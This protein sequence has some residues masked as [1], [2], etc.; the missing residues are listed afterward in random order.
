MTDMAQEAPARPVFSRERLIRFSDCDAAGIVYYPQYFV[1]C[2][3][4]VEDWFNE[5]LGVEYAG[6]V[7][8]RRT[9]LP[10][11][12]LETDFT[13]PSH[14][15][16]RVVLSLGVERLGSRS[17]TLRIQCTGAT[18]GV[19]RMS[20]RLVLV[21]TSLDTHQ[22]IS[23]PPDVAQAIGQAITANLPR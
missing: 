22:A 14:L 3:G 4:L 6:L 18:D 5:G 8:K 23:I 10:I 12:R 9:G 7:M 11:V 1:M 19:L 20:A 17:L 13:S 16:D 21:V 15:G 2:N